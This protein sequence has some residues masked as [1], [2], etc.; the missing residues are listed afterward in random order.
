MTEGPFLAFDLAVTNGSDASAAGEH[1]FALDVAA[2][3]KVMEVQRVVRVPLAPAPIEGVINHHGRI[4]TIVDPAPLFG[5]PPQSK[6]PGQV[7]ALQRSGRNN[8]QVALK[9]AR[10]DAIVA[11]DALEEVDV[12]RGPCVAKVVKHQGRLVYVVSHTDLLAALTEV[13]GAGTNE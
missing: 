13:F 3:G 2:V 1:T 11:A 9:V 10:S 7:V 5:L 4:V 6:A 12:P 8:G